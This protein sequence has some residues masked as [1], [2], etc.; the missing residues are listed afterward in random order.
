MN[1]IIYFIVSFYYINKNIS[2]SEFLKI[3]Q[4]FPQHQILTLPPIWDEDLNIDIIFYFFL[5]YY[6]HL[7]VEGIFFYLS[8]SNLKV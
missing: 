2:L 1:I 4:Y 8:L 5:H 6:F 7:L 3:T